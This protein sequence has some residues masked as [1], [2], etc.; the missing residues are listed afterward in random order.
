MSTDTALAPGPTERFDI[1]VDSATFSR[2]VQ[3]REA[4]GA[5]FRVLPVARKNIAWVVNA[6]AEVHRVLVANHR[7][8]TKGVGFERVALMLGNGIIV[9]D[10]PR[11][12]DQ[13]RAMQPAFHKRVIE[14]LSVTMHDANAA[15][16]SRW[17][18]AARSGAEIDLTRDTSAVALEVILRCLFSADLDRLIEREGANPFDLLVDDTARDLALAM[19]FRGLGHHIVAMVRTRR[20]QDRW[21]DD[22]LS[23]LARAPVGATGEPMDERAL[24]DEVMTLVVAGHET[25]AG[26][27]NWAWWLLAGA[28]EARARLH[29]EVDALPGPPGFADLGALD[30][31]RQ[32]IEET[33]RLYP[34]V[35]LFSR[36]AIG[37]D[38]LGEHDIAAG[39]DIFLS[40]YLMQRDPT[41][42]HAA[43][44]F[45]PER[46][47]DPG[48]AA[49][50]RT[51]W[52]PFSLGMRRCIGEFFS[53][54]DMQLHLALIA[55]EL[56]L[57]RVDAVP[58]Q[59]EPHMNLRA[60]TSIRVRPR[61]RFETSR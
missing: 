55:R 36:K 18:N 2:L 25:T 30:Y 48:A 56:R 57:D 50:K 58:P 14:R 29:A 15:L 42:W 51:A 9:S 33:L 3:W 26:T 21:P 34:P 10:G 46:F 32:V 6:P 37:E 54:V 43:D 47:A 44:A 31:T 13:R 35:W 19:R 60:A 22:W 16:L 38:R 11:W 45:R 8:Y 7:N 41:Y 61:L 12:R 52:Y 49:L 53:T 1:N 39:S 40:P 4:H 5:L 27:L 17:T 24:V 59:L 20:E 23:M 28:P